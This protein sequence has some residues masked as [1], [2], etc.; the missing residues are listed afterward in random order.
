MC[1]IENELNLHVQRLTE[2]AIAL[3]D[4]KI[5]KARRKLS[6]KSK[7]SA[8]ARESLMQEIER[9]EEKKNDLQS[10]G[11]KNG[12]IYVRKFADARYSKD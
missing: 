5:E 9:M 4:K 8:D 1:H 7:R 10:T 3:Y 2:R 12:A 6:S 11:I